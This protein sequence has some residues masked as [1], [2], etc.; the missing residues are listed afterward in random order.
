MLGIELWMKTLFVSRQSPLE[1]AERPVKHYCEQEYKTA[2]C[3][4]HMVG[5]GR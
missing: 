3:T 5:D 1:H 2:T 4:S